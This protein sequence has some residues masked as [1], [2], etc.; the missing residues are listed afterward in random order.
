MRVYSRR[1]RILFAA[2]GALI[3]L[4]LAIV[5]TY[6]IVAM[7]DVRR[8]PLFVIAALATCGAV[9]VCGKIAITG[10]S[11][12]FLEQSMFSRRSDRDDVGPD[13]PPPNER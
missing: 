10:S 4:P 11:T 9:F 12:R 6:M 13:R 3:F 5:L 1:E 7:P 2:L 8:D